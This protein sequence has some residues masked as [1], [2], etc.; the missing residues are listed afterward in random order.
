MLVF[1]ERG[2]RSTRRKTSWSKGENQQQSQTTYGGDAGI[3]TRA[4]LVA[5]ECCHHCAIPC[6]PKLKFIIQFIILDVTKN[7]IQLLLMIL[8]YRKEHLY[9]VNWWWIPL[10]SLGYFTIHWKLCAHWWFL[11]W[12]A[13]FTGS[14]SSHELSLQELSSK[15]LCKGDF[16]NTASHLIGWYVFCVLLGEEPQ[17]I[18]LVVPLCRLR[19]IQGGPF[20]P[21][22]EFWRIFR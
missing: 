11:V 17:N 19:A 20:L 6:S 21:E 8:P 5:G 1:E 15:Q 13:R 10:F 9:L 2:N 14:P 3:W 7:R 22:Y 4:T 18:L 12:T 16:Y